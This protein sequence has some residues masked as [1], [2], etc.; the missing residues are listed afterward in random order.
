MSKVTSHQL[1]QPYKGATEDVMD[2]FFP[3]RTSAEIADTSSLINTLDK[4]QGK[5]IYNSTVGVPFWSNGAEPSDAWGPVQSAALSFPFAR[6]RSLVDEIGSV[7]ITCVRAGA[8]GTTTNSSGLMEFVSANLPRW[9]YDPVTLESLGI[10]SEQTRANSIPEPYN[11]SD[12]A[13]GKTACTVDADAAVGPTGAT[14]LDR[15]NVTASANYHG[16]FD[17][18]TQAGDTFL[19]LSGFVRDD[20]A[21]FAAMTYASG[22]HFATMVADLTTGLVTDTAVGASSGNIYAADVEDWGG[23]LYRMKMVC[24]INELNGFVFLTASDSGTPTYTTSGVPTYTAVAGEDIFMGY[25]QH[26]IAADVTTFTVGTRNTDLLTATNVAWFGTETTFYARWRN[27]AT[28]GGNNKYIAALHNGVNQQVSMF[29]SAIGDYSS[30][31]AETTVQ[32]I[33]TDPELCSS[34]KEH[35]ATLTC[36]AGDFQA[37]FDGRAEATLGASGNIPVGVTTLVIGGG[38]VSNGNLNGII[39]DFRVY[40]TRKSDDFAKAITGVTDYTGFFVGDSFGDA[41]GEYT[42]QVNARGYSYSIGG[43]SIVGDI[44]AQLAQ[45]LSELPA[46]T[47]CV[48][49]GGVNDMLA[50]TLAVDVT[51]TFDAMVADAKAAGLNV[52][53]TGIAPWTGY[54]THTSPRQTQTDALNLYMSQQAAVQGYTY[55]D[56]Y[57]LLEDPGVA[58]T[59]LPVYDSGDNLHPSVYGAM[60]IARA[61]DAAIAGF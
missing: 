7:T 6:T 13:W 45:A 8:T 34:N 18:L 61:I 52:I 19:G 17:G 36:A 31:V 40:G 11:L 4:R 12:A 35:K 39:S 48:I 42:T 60:I 21:G 46:A 37:I 3:V 56:F 55:L 28:R 29:S 43:E 53:V 16:V 47:W 49:Q 22:T 27:P 26:E 14:D 2:A 15:I 57:A 59:M 10:W 5:M 30:Y 38:P 58:D 23:G 32:H 54:V 44:E 33:E 41:A 24:K 1:A 25:I 9:T 51:P 20:G 50:D